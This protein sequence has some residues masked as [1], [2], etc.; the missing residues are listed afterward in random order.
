[1]AKG[2]KGT[3]GI[4]CSQPGCMNPPA[5]SP[6][7]P[8]T[9]RTMCNPCATTRQRELRDQRRAEKGLPPVPRVGTNA[10]ALFTAQQ[11]PSPLP[12]IDELIQR[13]VETGRR[14]IKSFTASRYLAVDVHTDGP[15]GVLFAGDP[16]MDDD[17]CDFELLKSHSE[18]VMATDGLFA[19]SVGDL[20]NNWVGRLARLYGNQS[21]TAREAWALVEWW[22][23][24]LGPKLLAIS[25]GNHD[26][27]ARNVHGLDPVDWVTRQHGTV[28]QT[29]GARLGL[30]TPSG[31]VF[32]VNMR[33]DFSGRSQFNAAH[34]PTRAAIFGFKDDLL[35][36][37]HTHSTGLNVVKDP[38][39]GR[40]CYCVR[41]G[42][43][44]TV[45]EYAIERGFP[46]GNI[47]EC[48]LVIFDP[49]ATDPRHR[50]LL[51]FD[52]YRGAKV[53]TMMRAEWAAKQSPPSAKAKRRR[54]A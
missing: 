42:S 30:T 17:G 7:N 1:M 15:F 48:A 26:C 31:E 20:A 16:H 46:D 44:K 9:F 25:A 14:T 47:S 22:L 54:A 18:L 28:Y 36:S 12:P 34:G 2:V 32:T 4:Q 43:Y 23:N 27:W 39:T 38:A 13:R 41:L 10:A 53:L 33:H 50:V 52:P 8:G 45:D 37:G 19:C 5:E 11:P 6:T 51:D 24:F 29:N 35:I 40:V 49:Y 21:T 3:A